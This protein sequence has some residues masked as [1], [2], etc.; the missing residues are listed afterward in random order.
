MGIKF[1]VK[2]FK[3]LL[4]P[5]S[6]WGRELESLHDYVF[7]R[8]GMKIVFGKKFFVVNMIRGTG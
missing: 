8:R 4:G 7:R 2:V 3:F 6:G 1:F 5:R